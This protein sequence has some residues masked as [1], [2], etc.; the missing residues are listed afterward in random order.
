MRI[1]IDQSSTQNGVCVWR[2]PGP[3]I[4]VRT[5]GVKGKRYDERLKPLARA[6]ID[7]IYDELIATPHDKLEAIAMESFV[8][9][10]PR[11]KN[12]SLRKL[13]YFSGY[14]RAS[15][16]E[17]YPLVPI[18]QVSKGKAPKTE[19]QWLARSL[20]LVGNSHETDALHLGLLAGFDREELKS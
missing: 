14:L 4:T 19:A 9:Y 8:S 7:A 18:I 2:F 12:D 11:Y 13:Y 10:Q 20:G 5:V 16:E 3:H 1:S 6:V 17:C 15:L